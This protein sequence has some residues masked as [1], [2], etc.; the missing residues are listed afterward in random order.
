MHVYLVRRYCGMTIVVNNAL[1]ARDGHERSTV[2]DKPSWP[3]CTG[4]GVLT[5]SVWDDDDGGAFD[6]CGS[7]RNSKSQAIPPSLP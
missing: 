3:R 4:P 2:L 6:P 7:G 1:F 5:D